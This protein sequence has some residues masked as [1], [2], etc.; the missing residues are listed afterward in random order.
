MATIFLK[1]LKIQATI[2]AFDWEQ[3]IKQ[4][5][6][7]DLEMSVDSSI[8]AASD[9]LEDTIDYKAIAK[10]IKSFAE[11]SRFALIETLAEKI[12]EII[13]NEFQLELV[14]V[15]VSKPAAVRGS[16]TVGITVTVDRRNT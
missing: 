12:A 13:I 8:A 14:T 15:T 3:Q 4:T 6:L 10:R 2:G 7:I 11:Q 9:K 16:K 1:E 5:V